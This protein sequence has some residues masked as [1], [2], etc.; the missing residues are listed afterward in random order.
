MSWSVQRVD[1]DSPSARDSILLPRTHLVSGAR[2]APGTTPALLCHVAEDVDAL[3]DP[4]VARHTVAP[5][6]QP[7]IAVV[8][9]GS[10][11][12]EGRVG[13][14]LDGQ[15]GRAAFQV[16]GRGL[17]RGAPLLAVSLPRRLGERD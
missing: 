7:V 2:R 10:G 4:R 6:G 13:E 16:G 15:R 3:L 14:R 12:R 9:T 8:A 17:E 11:W 1:R 5:A